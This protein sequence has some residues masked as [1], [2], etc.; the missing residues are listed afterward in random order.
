MQCQIPGV[1]TVELLNQCDTDAVTAHI[2]R[3]T[4][5]PNRNTQTNTFKDTGKEIEKR[6]QARKPITLFKQRSE[7]RPFLMSAYGKKLCL[8]SLPLGHSLWAILDTGAYLTKL[9][10]AFVLF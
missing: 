1:I 4:A 6:Q 2:V 8:P 5:Y 7:G 3:I 9:L 10:P